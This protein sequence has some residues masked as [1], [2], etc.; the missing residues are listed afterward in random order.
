MKKQE[1]IKVYARRDSAT[2]ALRKLGVKKE[3]YNLF[4]RL[5][6]DPF[7]NSPREYQC[8]IGEAKKAVFREKN[9]PPPRTTKQRAARTQPKKS[10]HAT[11]SSRARELILDGKTNEEVFSALQAE[12]QLDDEKKY[13]PSWYRCELR[14]NGL[15]PP[16]FDFP[17][18]DPNVIHQL[19]D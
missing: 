2:S 11:I 9:R 15:L 17:N 16:G 18:H 4:I 10:N 6:E 13:Y 7:G 14:R 5:V 8:N 12:F 1:D 19:E 3:D